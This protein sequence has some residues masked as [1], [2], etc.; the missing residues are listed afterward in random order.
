[1]TLE[2]LSSAA[3]AL[4]VLAKKKDADSL[5]TRATFGPGALRRRAL[6][7]LAGLGTKAEKAIAACLAKGEPAA[8]V[9]AVSALRVVKAK[10]AA[11]LP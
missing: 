1:M 11:K 7:A 9:A 6:E 5:L 2:D 4:H 10:S 3:Q 8:R